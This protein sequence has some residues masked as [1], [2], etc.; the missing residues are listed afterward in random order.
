MP[1]QEDVVTL[2]R[3]VSYG[4]YSTLDYFNHDLYVLVVTPPTL[5]VLRGMQEELPVLEAELA[6][7]ESNRLWK[8]LKPFIYTLP[9]AIAFG[10]VLLFLVLRSA[11]RRRADF[12][13]QKQAPIQ[14]VAAS[15]GTT[16]QD[17]P[18]SSPASNE[19]SAAGHAPQRK[20][21]ALVAGLEVPAYRHRPPSPGPGRDC[22][23]R[24]HIPLLVLQERG[25]EPGLHLA[26]GPRG[27]HRLVDVLHHNRAGRRCDS[28]RM[29][30]VPR[31][32]GLPAEARRLG[33]ERPPLPVRQHP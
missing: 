17:S 18:S 3:F 31:P 9:E 11:M 16:A 29:D 25:D 14:T 2:Q 27:R 1:G 30:R 7:V 13:Q 6:R 15:R 5:K 20:G 26:T 4:G 22:G 32:A 33:Q 19:P 24:D 23:C 28:P 8:T 12:L 21:E 10:V